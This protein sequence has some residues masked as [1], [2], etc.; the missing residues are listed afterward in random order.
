MA[1]I[2]VHSHFE[3]RTNGQQKNEK[4]C[5]ENN[6]ARHLDRRF[7]KCTSDRLKGLMRN[8]NGYTRKCRKRWEAETTVIP[9]RIPAFTQKVFEQKMIAHRCTIW[10]TNHNRWTCWARSKR[11]RKFREQYCWW[12][13]F[14]K[15]Y[16]CI[17]PCTLSICFETIAFWK[18]SFEKNP[19]V[20]YA[21]VFRRLSW[22]DR[23]IVDNN[24]KKNY[25]TYKKSWERQL[26]INHLI[27]NLFHLTYDHNRSIIG[28][29]NTSIKR[30]IH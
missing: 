13:S 5:L 23:F 18:Q 28:A 24:F 9:V 27:G 14:Q 20:R 2:E 25:K 10:G 12:W 22:S 17:V 11:W 3:C 1:E 7:A 29:L 21:T 26:L 19:V 8:G 16:H 4:A 6:A 15:E 30:H